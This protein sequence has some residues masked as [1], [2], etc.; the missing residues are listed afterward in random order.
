MKLSPLQRVERLTRAAAPVVFSLLAVFLNVMALP[1]PGAS[2]LAPDAVLMAMFYWTVHRPDLMRPW[3]A[4]AIG[5]LVDILSG[6]PLG[7]NALVLVLVQWTIIAQH[8]VFRGK[9]FILVWCAFALVALGAKA[10]T[11]AL[12]LVL[13]G[14][15]VGREVF[16]AELG[17]TVALYPALAWIMGRVQRT[18]LA[19]V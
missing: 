12:A 18:V 14:A 16:L 10:V 8:K 11:A 3:A 5:L 6:A 19:T 1:L 13:G 15:L 9:S 17:L 7:A 4:F 2:R